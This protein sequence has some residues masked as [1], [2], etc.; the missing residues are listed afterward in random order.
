MVKTIL[1]SEIQKIKLEMDSSNICRS[2]SFLSIGVSDYV[3]WWLMVSKYQDSPR[4]H[5]FS[6]EFG[7]NCKISHLCDWWSNKRILELVERSMIILVILYS[8][9]IA[10]LLNLNSIAKIPHFLFIFFGVL[11]DFYFL[12]PSKR[13]K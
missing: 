3:F 9:L 11:Y 10:V 6:G 8:F 12:F 7:F 5:I 1:S 13:F 2:I 4:M